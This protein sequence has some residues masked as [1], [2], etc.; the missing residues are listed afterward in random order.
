[1]GK[2]YE[3]WTSDS[4]IALDYCGGG[5]GNCLQDYVCPNLHLWSWALSHDWKSLL[6]WDHPPMVL[7][8]YYSASW[9]SLYRARPNGRMHLN[10]LYAAYLISP[11][12]VFVFPR[13][14]FG[15]WERND[16]NILLS[17]LQYNRLLDKWKEMK[18]YWNNELL[19]SM[20]DCIIH[21]YFYT[22]SNQYILVLN[23]GYFVKLE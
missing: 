8:S 11:W 22:L 19:D 15:A 1:M 12:N 18:Y 7:A 16:W 4:G 14:S 23:L 13:R 10:G 17:L 9:A 21:V 6:L 2:Y 5:K 20:Q 3:R